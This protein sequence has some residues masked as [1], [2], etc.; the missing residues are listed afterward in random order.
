MPVRRVS[1]K[2]PES[3]SFDW[4]AGLYK[5]EREG[6]EEKMGE[7]SEAREVSLSE[8]MKLRADKAAL[9]AGMKAA[10]R[11]LSRLGEML[12]GGPLTPERQ[13]EAYNLAYPGDVRAAIC[14]EET[15][16]DGMAYADVE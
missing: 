2:A 6:K 13:R 1:G 12:N 15:P 9:L 16:V 4:L 14:A 8:V 10:E 7:N 11:T 3:S 5:V